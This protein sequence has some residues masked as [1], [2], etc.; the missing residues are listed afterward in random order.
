MQK[1]SGTKELIPRVQGNFALIKAKGN[2]ISLIQK[3]QPEELLSEVSKIIINA[4]S[5]TR[6]GKKMDA[7]GAVYCA[8]LLIKKYWYLK[9]EEFDLVFDL[10]IMGDF[11]PLFDRFDAPLIFE[12]FHKYDSKESK[13]SIFREKEL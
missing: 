5:M 6:V 9:I 4:M 12:W 10:G 2:Q 3:E 13:L 7:S 8:K 11:G 1:P